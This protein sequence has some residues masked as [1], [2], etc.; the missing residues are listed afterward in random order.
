MYFILLKK[1]KA[2][3]F[4]PQFD[5]SLDLAPCPAQVIPPLKFL[6]LARAQNEF[7]NPVKYQ[8]VL[9]VV[10]TDSRKS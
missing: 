10:F 4:K 3:V 6:I 5:V 8:I 7:L 1:N 9:R 2:L